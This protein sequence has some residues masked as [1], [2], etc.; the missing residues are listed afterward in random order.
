MIFFNFREM[1]MHLNLFFCVLV[2]FAEIYLQ[3]ESKE[4]TKID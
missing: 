4:L 3:S 2:F 1:I